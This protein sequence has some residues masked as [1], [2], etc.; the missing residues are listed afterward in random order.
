MKGVV[1]YESYYGNTK[2]L[3]EAIAQQLEVDGHEVELRSVRE[4]HP[5]S[6]KGDIMFL[7]S[8]V[9]MGSVTGRVKRYIRKLDKDVWKH[10]P[11]VV[12]TTTMMLPQDATDEQKRSQEKWDR[13]AG[14]KLTDLARSR[15]LNAV[16]NHLWVE[17][18]GMKGPLVETGVENV[19]QF[20][21]DILLSLKD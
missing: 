14:R 11:I 4:H 16:Q 1:I 17:V 9:R 19:K 18:E 10:K 7:G 13:G 3:A 8:P 20:V 15:G 21:R 12:F 2:I 5:E 6:P